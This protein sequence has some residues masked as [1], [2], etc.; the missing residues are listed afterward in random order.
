M[1]FINKFLV[2]DSDDTYDTS[3]VVSWVQCVVS[4][5]TMKAANLISPSHVNITFSLKKSLRRPIVLLSFVFVVQL[6]FNNICLKHVGVAFFQVARSMTLIFTV[7]LSSLILRSTIRPRIVIPC[8]VIAF[9]FVLGIDQE[10]MAGTLSKSGVL[11]GVTSSLFVAINGIMTKRN[12]E[13][14]PDNTEQL[15]FY[16]NFNAIILFL[17]IVIAT[18][19][20][21]A[22][23]LSSHAQSVSF[24]VFLM[25][26]G[27]LA[28][29]M[30]WVSTLQIKLTSPVTHHISSNCKSIFQTA[31]AVLYFGLEKSFFWWLSVVCVVVGVFLYAILSM[32]SRNTESKIVREPQYYSDQ[33]KNITDY[34]KFVV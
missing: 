14:L 17:P 16:N 2:G 23:T 18:G 22:L 6:S 8:L 28:T 20:F 10:S 19:Q 24:W 34:K 5:V 13:I 9:G 32:R 1:V 21:Q 27:V 29:A 31:V 30:G 11:F 12:L 33:N 25:F 4:I 26:S 3:L 7:I 15:I